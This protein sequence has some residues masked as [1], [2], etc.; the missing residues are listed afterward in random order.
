ML[1]PPTLVRLRPPFPS[2]TPFSWWP[3]RCGLNPPNQPV[4]ILTTMAIGYV[5]IPTDPIE[6]TERSCATA[7][8]AALLMSNSQ[9]KEERRT[10]SDEAVC[11][12]ILTLKA[13]GC[14][15]ANSRPPSSINARTKDLLTT[16]IG[17]WYILAYYG[18][19]LVAPHGIPQNGR[20][21]S[22]TWLD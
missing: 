13:I 8:S 19:H 2:R 6:G 3:Y 14:T 10:G 5:R 12:S 20:L 18:S 21:E 17:N 7:Q 22:R 4:M 16:R 15:L 9:G 11:L 1:V